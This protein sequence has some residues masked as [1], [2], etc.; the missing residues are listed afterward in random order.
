MIRVRRRPLRIDRGPSRRGVVLRDHPSQRY[1]CELG[2]G[3][4]MVDVGLGQLDALG[5]EVQ[6]FGR[7][8]AKFP[9]IE[10]LDEVELNDNFETAP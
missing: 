5:D 2:I 6:R 4:E 9:Q 8:V 3:D 10:S 1:V 7:V